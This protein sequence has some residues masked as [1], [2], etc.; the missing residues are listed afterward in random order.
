[1][2]RPSLKLLVFVFLLGA[3][4]SCAMTFAWAVVSKAKTQIRLQICEE[5]LEAC[6]RLLGKGDTP[7]TNPE[8]F[9]PDTTKH[10]AL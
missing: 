9:R 7:D 4:T 5:Y 1:M 8:D 2:P 10:E 3:L 6:G